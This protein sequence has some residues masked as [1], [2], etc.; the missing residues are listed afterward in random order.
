[1][2]ARK[3][4]GARRL[5]MRLERREGD[6]VLEVQDDGRGTSEIR[7]G[8]GLASMRD[9]VASLGGRVEVD[10]SPGRGTRVRVQVPMEEEHGDDTDVRG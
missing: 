7:D 1:M 10:S 3:H 4:S 2:N 6:A 5:S 9:R 8:V